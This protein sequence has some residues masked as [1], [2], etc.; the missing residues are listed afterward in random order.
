MSGYLVDSAAFKAVGTSD[1]RPAGSIPVHLRHTPVVRTCDETRRIRR[2]SSQDLPLPSVTFL[3]GEIA[4]FR[5]TRGGTSGDSPAGAG[6]RTGGARSRL[7]PHRSGHHRRHSRPG[8]SAPC[9]DTPASRARGC[10]P[11]REDHRGGARSVRSVTAGHPPLRHA[12][13]MVVAEAI[14]RAMSVADR[15]SPNTTRSA[16]ER[17]CWES[18]H[19]SR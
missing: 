18:I 1:P 14:W 10:G 17:F 3:R 6:G 13:S 8:C 4:R 15:P 12:G 7:P 5:R 16:S 2:E 19:S 11:C 9:T